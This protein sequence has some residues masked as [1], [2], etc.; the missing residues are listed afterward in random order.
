MIRQPGWLTYGGLH[1]LLQAGFVWSYIFNIKPDDFCGNFHSWPG[2]I[3]INKYLC[4]D[5]QII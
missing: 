2:N 4:K 5:I 1:D 3:S